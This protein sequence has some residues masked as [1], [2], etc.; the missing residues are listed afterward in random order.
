MTAIRSY[1][2]ALCLCLG[3]ALLASLLINLW[4]DPCRVL[5]TPLQSEALDP[6]RG[7][8]GRHRTT[9]CGFVRSAPSIGVALIGSSRVGSGLD[10]FDPRWGRDDVYNLSYPAGYFY[11][12]EAMFRYLVEHQQPEL[13]ILG[14]DPGDLSSDFDSRGIGDFAG[15]PMGPDKTAL[16]REIRYLFGI[17]SLE[18]SV[19]VI[20]R[21]MSEDLP[22][23]DARGYLRRPPQPSMSQREFLELAIRGESMFDFPD[24]VRRS[25]P[26][27]P[28]KAELLHKLILTCRERD[29][30][31]ILL[32]HPMHVLPHAR[33]DAPPLLHFETERRLIT[34]L[35]AGLN[36]DAPADQQVDLW[37]FGDHHPINCDPLPEGDGRMRYWT[38]FN[39]YSAEVGG[40]MLARMLG[41]PMEL[42]AARDYGIRLTPENF[43][44]WVER[45]KEGYRRYISGPGIPDLEWKERIIRETRGG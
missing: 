11:E 27:D 29:I 12:N 6:Y 31:L 4:A 36:A 13:V 38:D 15:S 33:P 14:L 22:E 30:R 32:L 10:P 43:D 24:A 40:A 39:H 16:D 17:S 19:D 9:K 7:P 25:D 2:K 35:V 8:P 37:D 41:W 34:G 21:S 23:F 45:S 26:L 44:G 28:E 20:S 1:L 18:A 3:A 42:E 5:P